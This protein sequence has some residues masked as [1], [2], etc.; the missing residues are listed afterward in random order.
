MNK[1]V[2]GLQRYMA[3]HILP[4]LVRNTIQTREKFV[5]LLNVKY[6]RTRTEKVE[7][8]VE[9]LLKFQED[10]YKDDDKLIIRVQ[11]QSKN[12]LKFFRKGVFLC[13]I[14]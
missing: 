11:H 7:E 13:E 5:E 4:V 1:D 8:A 6:R 2:K 3:E 14:I 12:L 10:P 9:D